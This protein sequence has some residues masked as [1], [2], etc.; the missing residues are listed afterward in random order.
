MNR[1]DYRDEVIVFLGATYFRAVGKDQGFGLS[2][3]ALA[4]DTALPSGE[5]FPFFR[6]FWL[7]HPSPE[8]R[9]VEIY[10]LLDSPRIAG[11]YHFIVRPGEHTHVQVQAKLFA[12]EEVTKIGIAPLT[13]MFFY[14]EN[15]VRRFDDFRPEVHDSDG[16]LMTFHTGE[17]LWRPI[18][19]PPSLNVSAFR[20]TNPKGFGFLQ[21]DREFYH[22]EDLETRPE[23]RPSVWIIPREEWGQGH[24]ELVE[25]PTN[26]DANDNVVTYWVPDARPRPNH[27]LSVGYDMFWYLH[28][29]DRPPGGR[30]VA[31]RRDRGTYE[32]AHR[33]VVDFE[34]GRLGGLPSETVLRGMI[35][36][37]G[38]TEMQE[39]LLEQHV[40]KNP[41][42]GGWRLVFQVRPKDD[43]PLDLRAFLQKGN[44]TLTETW[45]YLL[46]P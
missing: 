3:R 30:A 31:T 4:V 33:F 9:E 45:S 8:A 22:Y 11:A 26:G 10:A 41:V 14:G 36:V 24:I 1:P 38:R 16:A 6:E 20:T 44:E 28:A 32:D 18:D 17:W 46:I 40:A 19:N 35:T 21:R 43:K 34:G 15:T 12:R 42:T 2:A 29:A 23:K 37:G 25:I 27:P 39:E 5:E 13:S 7:V